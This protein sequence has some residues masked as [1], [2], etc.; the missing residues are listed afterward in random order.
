VS[1]LVIDENYDQLLGVFNELHEEAKRL[2]IQ[3]IDL[4]ERIDGLRLY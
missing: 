1:D 3:K 2:N 4:K